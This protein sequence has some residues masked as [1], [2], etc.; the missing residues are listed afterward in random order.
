MRPTKI[1]IG[2]TNETY[3]EVK[4]GLAP[5]QQLLLLEAGQGRDLLDKAGI[6]L[7]DPT[8]KPSAD[9]IAAT[10]RKPASVSQE[11][12]T[13]SETAAPAVASNSEDQSP[14]HTSKTA[15]DSDAAP[16]SSPVG[17]V[18]TVIIDSQRK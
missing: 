5:G 13:S 3:A 2:R 17:K 7:A 16:R 15:S 8:T 12:K 4:N 11:A 14:A 18:A 9:A 6:K 1:E 10:P